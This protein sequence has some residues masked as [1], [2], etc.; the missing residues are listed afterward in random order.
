VVAIFAGIHG[1]LDEV[2]VD[3]V[4]RFQ[5]ELREH[6][7]TEG[8]ILTEIREKKELSD[9]LIERLHSELKAF[10]SRFNVQEASSIV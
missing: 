10:A 2:P 4:P 3:Q 1:Y 7:M 6:M 9:E 5:D 8:S